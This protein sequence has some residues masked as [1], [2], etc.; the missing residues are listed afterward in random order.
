M[1]TSATSS[2]HPTPS[3]ATLSSQQ[4]A[5]PAIMLPRP[6]SMK[7]VYPNTEKSPPFAAGL[8]L[9]SCRDAAHLLR[10]LLR[11]QCATHGR[12]HHGFFHRLVRIARYPQC[13]LVSTAVSRTDFDFVGVKRACRYCYLLHAGHLQ[14]HQ[15]YGL[16]LHVKVPI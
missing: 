14:L 11:E 2:S 8:S 5:M 12:K 10:Q 6:W 7:A 9:L 4:I 1:R 13:F 3:C 15:L 16:L